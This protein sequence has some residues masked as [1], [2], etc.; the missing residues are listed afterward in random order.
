MEYLKTKL[1]KLSSLTEQDIVEQLSR[2]YS[3]CIDLLLVPVELLVNTYEF[4]YLFQQVRDLI[5]ETFS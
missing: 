4:I 2:E 3:E 1:P 5:V